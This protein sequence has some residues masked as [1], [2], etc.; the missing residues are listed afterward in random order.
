MKTGRSMALVAASIL[1]S[2]LVLAPL[3]YAAET[4]RGA[5]PTVQSH[6]VAVAHSGKVTKHRRKHHRSKHKHHRHMKMATQTE[7]RYFS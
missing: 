3:T 2:S 6:T 1:G 5:T 7:Q 4:T